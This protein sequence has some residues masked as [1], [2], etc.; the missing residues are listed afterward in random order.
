[1][2]DQ[3]AMVYI[4]VGGRVYAVKV[5]IDFDYP[6]SNIDDEVY[7]DE[8][9]AA[10]MDDLW[11]QVG[12]RATAEYYGVRGQEMYMAPV[13]HGVFPD[14]VKVDALEVT[15]MVRNPDGSVVCGS[16]AWG[17]AY[18]AAVQLDEALRDLGVPD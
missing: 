15:P 5:A 3:V 8:D 7:S 1:M 13:A 16:R 14:G 9:I 4:D 11:V 18:E 12:L 6:D 10:W 17:V 2:S